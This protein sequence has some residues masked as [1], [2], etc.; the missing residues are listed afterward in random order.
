MLGLRSEKEGFL[1]FYFEKFLE[2]IFNSQRQEAMVRKLVLVE[3]DKK[4]FPQ[5]L[6]QS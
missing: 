5:N 2:K 3:D 6:I 1:V 4:V